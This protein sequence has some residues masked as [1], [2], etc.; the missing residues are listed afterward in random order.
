[1][2]ACGVDGGDDFFSKLFVSYSTVPY[3]QLSLK[4]GL[5]ETT[6][7]SQMRTEKRESYFRKSLKASFTG[8]QNTIC[9]GGGL[10]SLQLRV[11]VFEV[12]SFFSVLIPS[13]KIRVWE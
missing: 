10:K 7:C 5:L 12:S 4:Q 2:R 1:M 9:H 6:P 13:L 8:E 3:M 11:Q